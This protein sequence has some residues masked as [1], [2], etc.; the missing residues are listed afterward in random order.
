MVAVDSIL[1]LG[2]C[3]TGGAVEAVSAHARTSAVHTIQADSVPRTDTVLPRAGLAL[4]PEETGTALFGLEDKGRF[5]NGHGHICVQ[6]GW[7]GEELC[8]G[9]AGS[10]L[11]MGECGRVCVDDGWQRKIWG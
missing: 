3:L 10:V 7:V 6:P 9:A 5:E 1:A 8:W 2:A 11:G 4:G